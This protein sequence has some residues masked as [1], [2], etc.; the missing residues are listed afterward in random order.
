M[1][2]PASAQ[3]STSCVAIAG[4]ISPDAIVVATALP[5]SAPNKFV[6]AA[7]STACRGVS[8]F[9][10]TTVA[11]EFAVSWN[12]LMYS[13]TKATAITNRIKDIVA[14]ASRIL[15]HDV[16][17]HIAGVAATIDYFFQH[18]VQIAHHHRLQRLILAP[19]NF[20]QQFEHDI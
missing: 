17:H 14:R 1:I 5:H 12:P 9:V 20:A 18:V 16:R 19:V 15:H 10:A 4:S 7:I 3:I 11:I 13:N 2:A 6:Q 8:T